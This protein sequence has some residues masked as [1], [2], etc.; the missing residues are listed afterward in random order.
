M[1][2]SPAPRVLIGNDASRMT[3]INFE[4]V[5]CSHVPVFAKLRESG[6]EFRQPGDIYQVKV[7]SHGLSLAYPGAHG[8][9]PDPL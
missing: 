4:N 9:L 5:V 8:S 2:T 7:F 3:E 6:R 1:K